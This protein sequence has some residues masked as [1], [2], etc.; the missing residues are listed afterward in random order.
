VVDK[1]QNELV[2]TPMTFAKLDD[3]VRVEVDLAQIRGR[4]V[5]PA[6]AAKMKELGMD[7]VVS[8]TRPDKH[9]MYIVYP[10]LR[11]YVSM[12]LPPEEAAAGPKLQLETKA[13]TKETIDG[14][15]CVKN[16]VVVTDPSGQKREVLVWN[17]TDLKEFPIQIQ[18]T[19]NGTTVLMRF[20][21]VKL[22]RPDAKQFEPPAGFKKFA[23]LQR[24]MEANAAKAGN[25]GAAK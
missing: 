9:E 11:A 23:D 7:R 15:P 4:N 24:L 2:A 18:T 13:L 21:D 19:E 3:K 8:T 14:H 5:T 20:S 22:A 16:K 17:A 12:A 6:D 1:D 10:G 25:A